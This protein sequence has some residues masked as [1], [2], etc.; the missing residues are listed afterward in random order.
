MISRGKGTYA[1]NRSSNRSAHTHAL[2]S[3]SIYPFDPT[4]STIL[5]TAHDATLKLSSLGES[6]ITPVHSFSLHSTP[7]SHSLSSHPSS[8]LLIGVGTSDKTVRLLDLRSGLATHALPGHTGAVLSVTWAPHN[9][10]LIASASKD[11]RVIIFDV[12]RAG[13]HSATASLDMD[14]S[15]GVLRPLSAP[16]T[17]PTRQPFVR[18]ARAHNGA[19]T[20]VRWTSTGCH[21]LT[22][23]QDSRIRVW[24]AFTGANALVHFGPRIRNSASLHLA[25]RV[26]FIVPDSA[27]L[28]PGHELILWP[29]Y[30]DQDDRGEIFM[31]EF[32]DGTFVKQLRVPGILSRQKLRGRPTAL[33]AARINALAW[34]GNGASGEGMEM[35]SAHG[36]GT[37]RV[38]TSRTEEDE[39][40]E[41]EEKEAEQKD[42]KRKRDALE[43]VYRNLM[44]PNISFT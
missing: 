5:T 27:L 15:V 29:N 7:Y 30:N 38:W 40:L 22:A 16:S 13:H 37:V 11:N 23:G 24:D 32:R 33:T 4:P 6:E 26:P 43:E 34:R 8:L 35:Y 28:P 17:T 36:D 1:L 10:Y 21:L 31:L 44:Q 12:R 41:V 2:T 39:E 14:D 20:G 18:E 3:L 42:K 9:P 25:E 19:V